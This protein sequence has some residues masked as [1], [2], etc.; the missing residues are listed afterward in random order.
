MSGDDITQRVAS[1][2][3]CE[4]VD[5]LFPLSMYGRDRGDV[6]GETRAPTVCGVGHAV[7]YVLC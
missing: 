5:R 1:R 3:G 7:V 4:L 6:A 2:R